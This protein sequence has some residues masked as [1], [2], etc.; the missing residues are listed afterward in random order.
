MLRVPILL[1]GGSNP[2]KRTKSVRYETKNAIC[3]SRV[4]R[5]IRG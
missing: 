4:G 5:H 2:S 3:K 1:V